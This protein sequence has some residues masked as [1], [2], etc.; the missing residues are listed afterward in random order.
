[1]ERMRLN[2]SPEG[3]SLLRRRQDQKL[4]N[5]LVIV[6]SAG[7]SQAKHYG[8]LQ[9]CPTLCD[10]KDCSPPGSSVHRILQA[11]LLEW[12][13]ISFSIAGQNSIL[14]KAT[15]RDPEMEGRPVLHEEGGSYGG[16]RGLTGRLHP[17]Q[18]S[19]LPQSPAPS[20]PLP[21]SP[22][23]GFGHPSWFYGERI[24]PWLWLCPSQLPGLETGIQLVTPEPGR[25]K[26]AG[27][28][29]LHLDTEPLPSKGSRS[30]NSRHSGQCLRESC[31]ERSCQNR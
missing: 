8:Q 22:F 1:M 14:F 28:V 7:P 20:L 16:G 31:L 6:G 25:G 11:R 4:P 3:R 30:A 23:T 12:A 18:H 9:S 10:P 26:S 13:A 24:P 17:L 2:W 5:N 15:R 21:H 27:K 29:P 19:P